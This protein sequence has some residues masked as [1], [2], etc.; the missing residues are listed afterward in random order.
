MI[1]RFAAALTVLAITAPLAAENAPAPATAAAAS[2]EWRT[3]TTEAYRGKRDSVSFVDDSH[4]WYGTGAGDLFATTDGGTTW[5]KVASRPGT[6]VRAV[7]FVDRQN[8]FIGNI[9][10]DYYPGVTD[11]TPLYRSRDGGRTWEAVDTGAETIKGVCAIDILR[12]SRIYQGTLVPRSV[13]HAAGRV[14]GPTGI[15]RSVD[16]GDTWSVIDMA[17]HAGMI[18]DVKFFDEN[19]GL[20]FAATHPDPAQAEGLVLRTEDG[21]KTWR[22]VYRSGRKLELIWKASFPESSDTGYATVQSYDPER[23]TQLVIRSDDKGKTWREIEMAQD[24]TARQFGIGFVSKDVG[25]VGTAA[26][27]F[28]TK[29]GGKTWERAP[30]A[31]AANKFQ[32]VPTDKG[33]RLYAIGTEVQAIDLAAPP[34]D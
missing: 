14:G 8:G 5:E 13:I 6:F 34:T 18:L 17:P 9:G 29:D 23:A 1:E 26:G 12:V 15:L 31:R 19:T 32:A 27:G 7:G 28:A 10:T 2:G 22:E 24:K 3:F 4:G 11:T 16:G 30:I 21:G 33:V 20:V 25:F